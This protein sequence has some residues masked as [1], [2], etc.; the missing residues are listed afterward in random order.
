M[1]RIFFNHKEEMWNSWSHAGGILI[2][3]VV[4]GIFLYMCLSLIHI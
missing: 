2:G 1:R 4:G 3:T